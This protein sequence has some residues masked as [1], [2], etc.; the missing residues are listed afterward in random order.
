VKIVAI[1]KRLL[2]LWFV[3]VGA[4]SSPCFAQSAQKI[5]D[6]YVHAEGGAKALTRIQTASIT[7]NL[8][9]DSTGQS[10][11]YSLITKAPDKF[12]SEIII[13]PSRLI[14]AYNGK[15]AWGQDASG[16]NTSGQVIIR[17]NYIIKI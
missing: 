3:L 11:T 10:G 8:V 1:Q 4:G 12:Y 13:G 14:E 16:K 7:G 2:A 5:V 6:E 17:K 15:S 9:D